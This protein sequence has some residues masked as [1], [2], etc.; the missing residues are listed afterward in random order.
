MLLW[1]EYEKIDDGN[2]RKA[3]KGAKLVNIVR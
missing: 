3:I 1:I 2:L